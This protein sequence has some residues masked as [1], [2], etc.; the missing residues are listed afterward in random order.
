MPDE[1]ELVQQIVLAIRTSRDPKAT[2]LRRLLADLDLERRTALE[3]AIVGFMQSDVIF[4]VSM[5]FT[6]EKK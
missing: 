2:A 6:Q 4:D 3:Y 1:K 5:K